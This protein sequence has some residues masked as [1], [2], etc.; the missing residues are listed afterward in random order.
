M[1]AAIETYTPSDRS[2]M[3]SHKSNHGFFTNQTNASRVVGHCLDDADILTLKRQYANLNLFEQSILS[4]SAEDFSQFDRL[5]Y[6]SE[7]FGQ[8]QHDID[9]DDFTYEDAG[10]D[11]FITIQDRLK[12][13]NDE[14]RQD[15]SSTEA[16]V[17]PRVQFDTIVKAVDIF[18]EPTESNDPEKLIDSSVNEQSPNNTH[19][20]TV[21]LNDTQPKEGLSLV[22]Q[23]KAIQFHNMP[24]TDERWATTANNNNDEKLEAHEEDKTS[25]STSKNSM[26]VSVNGRFD[27]QHEDDY[28]AKQ[29]LKSNNNFPEK[30]SFLPTPPTEPKKNQNKPP[31]PYPI[32]PKSSE[33]IRKTDTNSTKKTTSDST[34]RQR[35]KSAGISKSIESFVDKPSSGVDFDE[36]LRKASAKKRAELREE[37]RKKED[38]EE[39]RKKE[40]AKAK[41]CY[42]RWLEEKNSERKRINEE[43]RLE[44]E[45]EETRQNEYGK[46]LNELR[47]R[48]FKEW[49]DRKAHE[50]LIENEFQKLKANDEEMELRRSSFAPNHSISNGGDHRAFRRWLRQKHEQALEEKR[51]IRLEIKQ[52]RRRDRRSIKRHQL[53]QDIQLAKS[54]GYS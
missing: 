50:A 23:I 18:L 21:P 49:L 36:L 29:T 1:T 11:Y 19:E 5:P 37:R 33:T 30:L 43:K 20:Y 54:Y 6:Q 48:R 53:Q 17:Q 15:L 41:E 25:P 8:D 4:N 44:K 40:L 28:I 10:A 2:S 47:E 27:L 51:R 13:A 14:F 35:P 39:R 3:I 45:E 46:E 32:R 42:E 34:N 52:R 12:K 16:K 24:P 38:E 31:R 7:I 26:I 22:E 9:D